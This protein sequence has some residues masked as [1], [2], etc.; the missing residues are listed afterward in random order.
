MSTEGYADSTQILPADKNFKA[1][2][3]NDII[4]EFHESIITFSPSE[5][6]P[7]RRDRPQKVYLYF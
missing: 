6:K 4:R 3:S 2:Q 7:P 1:P 5:R